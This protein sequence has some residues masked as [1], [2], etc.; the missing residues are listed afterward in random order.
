MKK[1]IDVK[2]HPMIE[3]KVICEVVRMRTF[4]A[5]KINS[6]EK[7]YVQNPGEKIFIMDLLGFFYVE[8]FDVHTDKSVK[9]PLQNVCFWE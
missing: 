8:I 7:F 5:V 1:N 4:Q 9:V 6:N 3:P 2:D